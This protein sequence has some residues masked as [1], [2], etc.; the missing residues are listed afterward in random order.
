MENRQFKSKSMVYSWKILLSLLLIY[1]GCFSVVG[2]TSVR[3]SKHL[4]GI[5]QWIEEHFAEGKIP[6][7]S[8]VYDGQPSESFIEQWKY[9]AEK[10]TVDEPDVVEYIFT[11][12]NP[13]NGLSVICNV[14]GYPDYHGVEWVLNFTNKSPENSRE[15]T[16]VNVC[17]LSIQYPTEGAFHLHYSEGSHI[18]KYDFHPRS[19]ELVTGEMKRMSPEG[20]RSSQGDYLPFFNI[21]SPAGQG[22]VMSVGWTGTWQAN[23]SAKNKNTVA[24]AAG[25]KRMNLYLYLDESI[26]TPSVSLMFWESKDRM[27][28][29]NQ[30]RRFILAHNSRKINGKLAEYPLSSGFNYRDP[31]PCGEYSCITSDYAI[32][33]VKRY[34]QFG[35]KP[36]VFWLDAGWH[37]D[38][39]DFEHGKSWANTTGNWTIDTLRFPKGLRPVADVIH[40][41]GTKFMVW[42][43]P[44]R[45]VRGTQWAVEYPE[46]MLEKTM[47]GDPNREDNTWLLFDLGNPEAC[48]WLS[49][50]IGDMLEKNGIDYYRQ[51][52]NIEPAD[53]WEA[54]DEPGRI[55]MKEIRYVEG[56]YRFWDYLLERFPNLLID[57]CASG[58]RRIDWETTGRSAPLWR[59]DYYHYYDTDGLQNQTYG[60]EFFLPIHGTGSLN[61]DK[62][63]FRSSMSSALIYN[64]KVTNTQASIPEMQQCL[65]EFHEIRPYYYEDYYPLTGTGDITPLNIWIAYQLHRP[66]DDSGIIVAFRRPECEEDRINVNLRGVT[67]KKEYKITNMDTGKV[68]NMSGKELTDGLMLEL[69]NPR[70]SLLLKYESVN[71]I[72]K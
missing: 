26:R 25:M 37:T 72:K 29:H 33:M 44:E 71:T 22:V 12:I 34:I 14:K 64:W 6:P 52:C 31:S 3:M 17:D 40:Q 48:E 39:S 51:D 13:T 35:L 1:T 41:V 7:F 66:S 45:V 49:K 60:L 8:F 20:G 57:N 42:F 4:P 50:Y 55:G 21:E 15:I 69:E 11:Y 27:D 2:Q 10:L 65:K 53:Y 43:E 63:S 58:G 9:S 32:A 47:Q 16:N 62:Y 5:E 19:I 70:S 46:W 18:S 38:A 56:L 59:S 54:N 36:E 28:G 61:T 30:F 68:L 67:P 23:I 24:M